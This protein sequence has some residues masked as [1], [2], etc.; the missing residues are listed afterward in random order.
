MASES[1]PQG[2]IFSSISP[3]LIRRR[4]HLTYALRS[5]QESEESELEYTGPPLILQG[6]LHI[7][8]DGDIETKIRISALGRPLP[9]P[10]QSAIDHDE[11][12]VKAFL[13]GGTTEKKPPE[14]QAE[15]YDHAIMFRNHDRMLFALE[16]LRAW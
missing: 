13:S 12:K 11:E 2:G 8:D 7:G 4:L 3:K 6:N 14:P 1:R 9:E 10:P 5:L 16:W 15:Y